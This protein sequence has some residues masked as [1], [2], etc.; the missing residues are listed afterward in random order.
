MV[1]P[2]ITLTFL[3]NEPPQPKDNPPL[4]GDAP[5]HVHRQ[6]AAA[7]YAKQKLEELM[8]HT[9]YTSGPRP[10]EATYQ[11]LKLRA[12]LAFLS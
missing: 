11:Q 2:A 3:R 8:S 6:F 10:I 4:Y 5:E 1:S 12:L 7:D 9:K